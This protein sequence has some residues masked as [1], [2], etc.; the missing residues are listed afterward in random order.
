MKTNQIKLGA[1]LSYVSLAITS[2]VGLIY[3][4]IMLRYMGQAEY[5][6]YSLIA[7]F[8]GYLTILDLGFGNAIIVYTAKYRARKS[9][10]DEEKLHGMFLVIYTI[11]GMIAGLIGVILYLNV[12]NFF[13]A[14]FTL[15]ELN[16][17]RIMMGI[18]TFNLVITFPFSI[19]GNIVT[20]YE[21]F[22]FSKLVNIVRQLLMPIIMIPLLLLGYKSVAMTVVVTGLNVLCLLINMMFC[23]KKL[24]IRIKF[25]GF[26]KKVLKEIFGYSFFI[27]LGTIVDK[28]NWSLDNIILGSVAGTV[29]VAL[30]SVAAQLN[31]IYLSFSTAISGVLLPKMTKMI[32]NKASDEEIS[33]EFVKTGRIQY[34][35][36]A[37]VINGFIIFGRE[38]IQIW[39]GSEY[40]VSYIIACILMIPV[41]IPLIQNVGINILQAKNKNKFRTALYIC[42]SVLNVILSIPLARMYGG[43]GAAIGTAVSLVIGNI[44]IMNI[45]YYKVIKIDIPR[46]W[47][48]ILKMTIPLTIIAIPAYF[49]NQLFIF[50]TWLT[51]I[52]KIGIFILIYCVTVY[53]SSMN[54]YEKELING[55]AKKFIKKINKRKKVE[56]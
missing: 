2:I 26:D 41:T 46:F 34:I 3:T 48:N 17:A 12:D 30:Y 19:F 27:F 4:P 6:L 21:E 15:E 54:K 42:I 40:S 44:F 10:D 33:N 38:F 32:E 24:N 52:I 8:I 5:G 51:L 43:V 35:I 11:I 1:I 53:F 39:S 13:G 22:I 23:L 29:A 55:V 31:N 9:K 49:I 28:I 7:S 50:N 45:Y 37:L 14:K 56:C 16:K 36:M 25:K 47:K 18:L 20:A